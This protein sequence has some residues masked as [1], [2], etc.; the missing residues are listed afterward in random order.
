M[1]ALERGRALQLTETFD[2]ALPERDAQRAGPEVHTR[3]RR[4]VAEYRKLST[5]AG[6]QAPDIRTG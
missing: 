3:F 6:Q 4:L 2:L 5:A 1:V